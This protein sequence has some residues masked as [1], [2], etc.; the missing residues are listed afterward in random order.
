[1]STVTLIC[2]RHFELGNCNSPGLLKIMEKIQPDLI[3]EELPLIVF[4]ECYKGYMVTLE[5]TAIKEYMKNRQINHIPIDTFDKEHT[6]DRIFTLMN[7]FVAESSLEY[8]N[9]LDKLAEVESQ[10]GF[11]FLNS[12]QCD[13]FFD[14]L[15]IMQERILFE[16]NDAYLSK[17]YNEEKAY[18]H[19]RENEMINNIYNFTK[20]NS[21]DKAVFFIG[22]GHRKSIIR[23]LYR[24]NRTSDQNIHWKIYKNRA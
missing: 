12:K 19:N 16:T 5:T 1:M 10:Q 9:Y 14:N 20:N 15:Y 11:A 22:A 8:R 6:M 3:F 13:T 17:I 23:K 24:H 21:Y 7:N 2:T 18:N 4:D